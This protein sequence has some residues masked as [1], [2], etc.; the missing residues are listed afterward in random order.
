MHQLLVLRHAKADRPPGVA[1]RDRP[2]AET[3]R[4]HAAAM[5]DAMQR[6]GLAPDLVLVSPSRRTMQTLEALEP[7]DDT[8]LTETVEDLYLA[9]SCR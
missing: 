1:D 7:W 3:G 8:P 4:K 9:D 5:R 2:L 6:L